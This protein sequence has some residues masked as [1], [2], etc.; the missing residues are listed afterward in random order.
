MCVLL[1]FSSQQI[2]SDVARVPLNYLLRGLLDQRYLMFVL[3]WLRPVE[4]SSA[5][6]VLMIRSLDSPKW[7]P[8][9]NLL[10]PF[11]TSVGW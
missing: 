10:F 7:K 3:P 4:I 5:V 1:Y 6:V 11:G 9:F 8:L 2:Y